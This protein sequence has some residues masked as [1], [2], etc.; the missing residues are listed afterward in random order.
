MGAVLKKQQ[1]MTNDSLLILT[2]ACF[3]ALGAYML[4]GKPLDEAENFE[5]HRR[6]IHNYLSDNG[7]L[8]G[9]DYTGGAFGIN[10]GVEI[11]R[12]YPL[13]RY[14]L[15][16][17][18]VRQTFDSNQ[19]YI[20]AEMATRRIKDCL[21]LKTKNTSIEDSNL[22][23]LM[24]NDVLKR[25]REQAEISNLVDR[26]KQDDMITLQEYS[27]LRAALVAVSRQDYLYRNMAKV[28]QL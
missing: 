12:L 26:I 4:A 6:L 18:D 19:S 5:Y 25:Y 20:H 2:L 23:K 14:E 11:S 27:Y 1:G 13:C 28:S 16:K 7:V 8:G 9:V 24:A 15:R 3:L 21:D 10:I 17:R 22:D